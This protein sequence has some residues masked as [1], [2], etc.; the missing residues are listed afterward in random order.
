VTGDRLLAAR[1]L[2][3]EFPIASPLLRRRIG[4]V[5]AVD[6]VDLDLGAGEILGVVGESGCGKTTLGRALLR[7]IEPT[8]G[9][10]RFGGEDLRALRGRELRRRRRRFQMVF[11]DPWS[12][13]NPRLRVGD[14]VFEPRLVHGLSVRADRA[15]EV[16][17]MLGEVGLPPEAAP[18]YPHEFSGGQRQRIGIARALATD[19]DLL[20]ADEP[21]SALDVSVRAQIVNLLL[22]VQARRSL[23]ILFIAHDLALVERIADRLVVLYLGRVVEEGPARALLARPLHPYTRALISAAPALDPD[24]RRA[25]IVLAGDPPSA[26]APPPGCPFHPRCPI[27][28]PRCATEAPRLEE[29]PEGR[30]VACHFPGELG[31]EGPI[32]GGTFP[33]P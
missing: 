19:P 25:R 22:E 12:S 15:A 11:Q 1:G 21:V 31:P 32:G 29:R 6:G 30:R 9:E 4:T 5:R 17:R 23:A 14:A 8:A 16:D 27:A 3:V 10:I 33:S 24:R 26:A 28:R 20:V 7:L 18:R 13:L 2:R